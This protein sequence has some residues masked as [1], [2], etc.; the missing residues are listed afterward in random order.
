M[1]GA[2]P[3]TLHQRFCPPDNC[4]VSLMHNL[5]SEHVVLFWRQNPNPEALPSK[6][7][8]PLRF[9][10]ISPYPLHL[11][12]EI[13]GTSSNSPRGLFNSRWLVHYI[14]L[15]AQLSTVIPLY[16]GYAKNL[17]AGSIPPP[18]MLLCDFALKSSCRVTSQPPFLLALSTNWQR[19]SSL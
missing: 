4:H 17:I 6:Q 5:I 12:L 9:V 10:Y 19:F 1:N 14:S 7:L 11:P 13:S 3:K 16:M 8:L 18:W 15:R 2:K